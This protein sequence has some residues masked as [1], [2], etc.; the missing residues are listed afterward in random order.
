MLKILILESNP[1]IS[2]D[3]CRCINSPS[4]IF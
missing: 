4:C 1:T 3:F 2:I